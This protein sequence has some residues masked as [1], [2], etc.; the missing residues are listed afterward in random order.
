M[1]NLF[2]SKQLDHLPFLV[3]IKW[4]LLFSGHQQLLF[5]VFFDL[6]I[7]LLAYFRQLSFEL[8]QPLNHSL[9]SFL[10]QLFHQLLFW[11]LLLIVCLFQL[12]LLIIPLKLLQFVVLLFLF[13]HLLMLKLLICLFRLNQILFFI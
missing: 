5:L 7:V 8:P 9:I 2:S 12:M 11:Q 13:Q 3:L 4:H 10:R 1:D 6:L